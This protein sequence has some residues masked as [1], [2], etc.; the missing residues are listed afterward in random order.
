[1][2]RR[3]Q[4]KIMS[5]KTF[6]GTP[7]RP[8]SFG[9]LYDMLVEH[10]PAHRSK[11]NVFDIPGIARDMGYAHETIYKAVREREPLKIGVALNLLKLSH[12]N[13][14]SKPL[15]WDDLLPFILPEFD[16]YSRPEGDDD[17][18]ELLD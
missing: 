14:D 1:V 7:R 16:N 18:S 9:P 2:N 6:T 15:F 3:Q 11:Q 13:Q 5:S 17:I 10:F 4:E 8:Y 12:E